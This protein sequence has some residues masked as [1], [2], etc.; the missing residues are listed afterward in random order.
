VFEKIITTP[1]EN[2]G[3]KYLGCDSCNFFH[4][5]VARNGKEKRREEEEIDMTMRQRSYFVDGA[6]NH[7]PSVI[8]RLKFT[9]LGNKYQQS[10][11]IY[12]KT[13]M[14]RKKV[15][16][17]GKP[18]V[19]IDIDGRESLQ[20]CICIALRHWN[21]RNI[22]NESMFTC[23]MPKRGTMSDG[24]KRFK[25]HHIFHMLFPGFG[26]ESTVESTAESSAIQKSTK[27]KLARLREMEA[28]EYLDEVW[29]SK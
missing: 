22:D 28:E 8:Y 13:I 29:I 26:F 27:E 1:G 25:N 14:T 7:S 16:E 5:G 6:E 3:K 12:E 11:Q 4:W 2:T 20:R 23:R 9:Y 15:K 19:T 18:I 17:S 10:T 24:C 21:I